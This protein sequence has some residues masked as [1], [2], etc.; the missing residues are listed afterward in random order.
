M[1][2]LSSILSANPTVTAEQLR[3]LHNAQPATPKPSSPATYVTYLSIGEDV[4][5]F[6]EDAGNVMG[7]LRAG[8]TK[9][10]T[11]P[12]IS[13]LSPGL[14]NPGY[15]ATVHDSLKGKGV[16]LTSLKTPKL[17]DVL[18]SGV[19]A[20]HPPLLTPEQAAALL[21]IGYDVV[22][23][24]TVEE[25]QAAIDARDREIAVERLAVILDRA[26]N[27]T[28]GIDPTDFAAVRAAWLTSF[29]ASVAEAGE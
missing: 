12:D 4:A 16:D 28:V 2:T 26:R 11:S 27:A 25:A 22:T 29:D 23:P 5:R 13:H 10:V 9:W 1:L 7:T 24:V 15:L 19:D 14:P 18:V 6:G 17:L 20:D 3:D 8:M 21:S